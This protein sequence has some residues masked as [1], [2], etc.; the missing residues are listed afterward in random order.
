MKVNEGGRD[1]RREKERWRGIGRMAPLVGVDLQKVIA[2][3]E[4]LTALRD[5]GLDPGDRT[6][7]DARFPVRG[8]VEPQYLSNGDRTRT[9]GRHCT[10]VLFEAT[11]VR[12]VHDRDG[13]LQTLDEPD[14]LACAPHFDAL[15]SSSIGQ[16]SFFGD[17]YRTFVLRRRGD[18]RVVRVLAGRAP[19]G[20][21]AFRIPEPGHAKTRR[22]KDYSVGW[23]DHEGNR[24]NRVTPC[25]VRDLA[26]LIALNMCHQ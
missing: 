11:T 19:N 23:S 8:A 18:E 15:G 5:G 9:A 10:P 24:Q 25:P 2:I 14:Q 3:F 12:Y 4:V 7:L 1:D 26:E 20:V 6:K 13:T 21:D 16:A 17:K 22:A